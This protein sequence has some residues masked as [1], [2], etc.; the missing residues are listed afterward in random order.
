MSMGLLIGI[1]PRSSSS[2]ENRCPLQT[3]KMKSYKGAR[4]LK[5]K[6]EEFPRRKK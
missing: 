3:S 4:L 1:R 5:R 6:T 2:R